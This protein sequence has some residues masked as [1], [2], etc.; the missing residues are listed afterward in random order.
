VYLSAEAY[1]VVLPKGLYIYNLLLLKRPFYFRVTAF[2][3]V[4]IK[5]LL[6][7]LYNFKKG[8]VNI[9]KQVNKYFCF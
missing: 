8:K 2:Y 3:K 1:T 7:L 6:K 9:N 5:F 4:S